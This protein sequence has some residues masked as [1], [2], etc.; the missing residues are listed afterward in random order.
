MQLL[1]DHRR[2]SSTNTEKFQGT[3]ITGKERHVGE[4][5]AQCK[6][7]C[8]KKENKLIHSFVLKDAWKD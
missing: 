6:L 2:I 4:H 1:K 3:V 7:T 8:I 5:Y